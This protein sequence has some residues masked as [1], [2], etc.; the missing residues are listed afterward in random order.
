MFFFAFQD[1]LKYFTKKDVSVLDEL[2]LHNYMK[3]Y[4]CFCREH[5]VINNMLEVSRECVRLQCICYADVKAI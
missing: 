1:F 5:H 4:L 3:E 2:V